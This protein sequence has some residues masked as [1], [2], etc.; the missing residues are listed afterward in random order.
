M[1]KGGKVAKIDMKL[2]QTICDLKTQ[3]AR[4]QEIDENSFDIKLMLDG[5]QLTEQT[6]ISQSGLQRQ[7][8]V[9]VIDLQKKKLPKK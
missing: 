6:L 3:I 8:T 1:T 4:L 9:K 7:S 5:K 2:D